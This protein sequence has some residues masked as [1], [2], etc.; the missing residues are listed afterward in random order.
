MKI[1]RIKS[2]LST[3]FIS[4]V[5]MLISA[6]PANAQISI[7]DMP[8]VGVII[9]PEEQFIMVLNA[10]LKWVFIP[11]ASIIVV[12]L[13]IKAIKRKGKEK[14]KENSKAPKPSK[15]KS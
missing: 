2:I 14:S 3:A 11:V 4:S 15:K 13:I 8:T 10:L 12:V 5:A 9:S 1:N 6:V 7:D